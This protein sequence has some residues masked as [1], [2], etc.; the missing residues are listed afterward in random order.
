MY[1]IHSGYNVT[2]LWVDAPIKVANTPNTHNVVITVNL[3]WDVNELYNYVDTIIYQFITF[4]SN[5]NVD[6]GNR[7]RRNEYLIIPYCK[8][9]DLGENGMPLTRDM[10][11]SIK[12]ILN[13][14]NDNFLA[15]YIKPLTR[16]GSINEEKKEEDLNIRNNDINN[17]NNYQVN[18]INQDVTHN[19][20]SQIDDTCVVCI[21]ER[22]TTMYGC[23]HMICLDCFRNW[24][25]HSQGRMICPLCRIEV[26]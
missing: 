5:V 15:F 14:N 6:E 23:C 20:E 26:V 12:N 25:E 8:N 24:R 10:Y 22:G 18:N 13:I 17:N 1:S 19:R 11:G 7:I 3:L 16:N 4:S 9:F 21:H 2:A